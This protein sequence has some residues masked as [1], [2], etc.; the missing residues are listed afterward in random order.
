M[1]PRPAPL[2]LLDRQLAAATIAHEAAADLHRELTELG[3]DDDHTRALLKESAFLALERIPALARPLHPPALEWAEQELLDPPAAE[4]T[5]RRLEG[6]L[7]ELLPAFAELHA[8][9]SQIVVELLDL[10]GRAR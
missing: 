6:D 9:Q 10:V 2:E 5:A 7:T 8:R 4:R 1:T 3:A